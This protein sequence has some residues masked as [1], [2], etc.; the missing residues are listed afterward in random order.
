MRFAI[1]CGRCG[2]SGRVSGP[3]CGAC[4]GEGRARRE[5]KVKVRVPPG[6]D[7]GATLR[8]QG[9]G[10]AGRGGGP[11][12]NLLLHVRV[13][14]HPSFRREGRDLVC[15]VSVGMARAALGGTVDVPTLNGNA[16]VTLP[17]GTKSGQKLRLRGKGVAASRG[18]E[19]GDL[20]AVI[21]I[22]TPHEL[23][24]RSRELLEE[25]ARLNPDPS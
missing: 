19:A 16:T 15:D 24:A 11:P 10:D 9:K 13:A 20:Y 3:P 4:A 12:G 21:Q 25:F 17:A 18:L 2:G 7:D 6:I 5:E 8:I 23:D 14:A 1:S 22:Y